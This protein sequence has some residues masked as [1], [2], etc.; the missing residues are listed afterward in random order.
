MQIIGK[1]RYAFD[2]GSRSHF[3]R[4]VQSVTQKGDSL[5][6]SVVLGAHSI[7]YYL[8]ASFIENE[9]SIG[10]LA[11][12]I[13]KHVRFSSATTLIIMTLGKDIILGSHLN[14]Y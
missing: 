13:E 2:M 6:V 10:R 5:Q 9:Y 8:A 3:W 14:I 12:V 1:D 7:F 11:Q 4:Y